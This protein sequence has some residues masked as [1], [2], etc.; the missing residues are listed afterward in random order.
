MALIVHLGLYQKCWDIQKAYTWAKL[1]KS[2][3]I[4]LSYPKGLERYDQETGEPLYIIMRRN[5]YG[6]PNAA[7]NYMK[8]RDEFIMKAFNKNGW[9]CIKSRMDPCFFHLNKNGRRSWLLAFVDDIDCASEH[10]ED[11]QLIFDTMNKEW[12]CKEVDFSYMVG[13]KRTF[14]NEEGVRTMHMTMESYIEGMFHAFKEFIPKRT[15]HTS[16][17]PG[18]LLSLKNDS[19]PS[20]HKRVLDRG[21]QRAIG[22]ILWAAR[23]VYPQCLYTIGQLCKV[24]SKPTEHA[25]RAAMQLIGF[26]HDHRHDGIKFRSDGNIKPFLMSD[27]SNKADPIDSKRAYG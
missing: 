20:E 18:M 1:D 26:M 7:R 14:T 10:P 2:D 5:L 16:C 13:V 12:K 23:G 9:K 8:H 25:W 19:N 11:A 22:M 4:I 15:Q 27:A 17:D 3:L 6:T 21:Y 24:M